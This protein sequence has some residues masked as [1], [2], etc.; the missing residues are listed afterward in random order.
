LGSKGGPNL[1][2]R[3]LIYLNITKQNIRY[4]KHGDNIEKNLL[5]AQN[6]F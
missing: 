3:A 6:F 4:R 2:S 1:F 5:G